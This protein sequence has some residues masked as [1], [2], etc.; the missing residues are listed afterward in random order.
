MDKRFW[1][2][3]L[4]ALLPTWAC[5]AADLSIGA[6]KADITPEFPIRLNGYAARK[7][8]SEGVEEHLYARALAIGVSAR[9]ASILIT[10]D[11]TGITAQMADGVAAR[12]EKQ[13]GIPR[14]RL[15]FSCTH[16]HTAPC[17]TGTIRNIFGMR[18]PDEQQEHIDRYTQFLGDKLVEV[19]QAAVADMKP[20]TLWIGRGTAGFAMNRRTKGEPVDHEMPLLVAKDASGKVRAL[21]AN[22]ACHC[23]TLG[24]DLNKFCG[25]WAG[26]AAKDLEEAN[27]GIVSLVTI[28]CGADANPE[29]RGKLQMAKDHG[30]VIADEAT[31]LL[32]AELRPIGSAP[33]CRLERFNLAFDKLPDR[34]GWETIAKRMDAVG[35]NARTQLARLDRGEQ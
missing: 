7:T 33:Q 24:S 28:G 22:Y 25:D 4:L 35:F 29:P 9:E 21:V 19:A 5:F 6:A 30:K 26:Y 12:V 31:R 11:A 1:L 17:L 14:E 10:L 27:P 15:V 13:T 8:E 3:V 34:A 32:G 23:T 16:S 18:I 2:G 20:G